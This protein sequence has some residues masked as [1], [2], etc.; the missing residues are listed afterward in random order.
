MT[1]AHDTTAIK[2]R[3]T[4]PII[5]MTKVKAPTAMTRRTR[6]AKVHTVMREAII[7]AEVHRRT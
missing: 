5:T 1:V 2:A 7:A 6:K 4:N 3:I